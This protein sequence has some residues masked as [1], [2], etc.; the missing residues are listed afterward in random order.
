[1][2]ALDEYSATRAANTGGAR[3]RV[4]PLI[5]A[6]VACLWNMVA[7]NRRSE[8][9]FVSCGGV[10]AALALLEVCPVLQRHQVCGCLAD[11]CRNETVLPYLTAWRSE[12]SIVSS[13]ELLARVWQDE[14]ERLGELYQWVERRCAVAIADATL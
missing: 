14:E 13:A 3:E 10:D 1:M 8:A 9:R 12:R 2:R 11:L 4:A 5:A 7:G 6:A